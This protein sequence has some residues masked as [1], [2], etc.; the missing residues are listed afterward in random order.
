MNNRT[1]IAA[2]AASL[3]GL[4]AQLLAQAAASRA[5]NF[6]ARPVT[7]IASPL[8]LPFACSSAITAG[9]PPAR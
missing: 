4:P 9:T 6:P 3:A 1:L 5:E 8:S 7:V 2:L